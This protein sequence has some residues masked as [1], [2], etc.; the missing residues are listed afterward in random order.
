MYVCMYVSMYIHICFIYVFLCIY[1]HTYI[2]IYISANKFSIGHTDRE[3][4][5]KENKVKRNHQGNSV[6]N[7]GSN[8]DD[9]YYI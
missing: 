2:Y 1:I 5:S 8:G 3:T 4:T 6:N 9:V 7:C